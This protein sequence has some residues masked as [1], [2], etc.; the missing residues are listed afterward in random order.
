MAYTK[1]ITGP[2][3]AELMAISTQASSH[4]VNLK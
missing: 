2:E 1:P 4:S 3:A